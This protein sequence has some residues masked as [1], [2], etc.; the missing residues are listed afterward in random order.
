MS[1]CSNDS[2]P[3]D[4]PIIFPGDGPTTA[5]VVY[6][7][8]KVIRHILSLPCVYVPSSSGIRTNGQVRSS[9]V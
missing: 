1:Q 4:G 9:V 5:T 2:F 7:T 3:G 6:L 8:Y